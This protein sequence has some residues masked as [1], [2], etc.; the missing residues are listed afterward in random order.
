VRRFAASRDLRF[1]TGFA[2]AWFLLKPGFCSS[3][4]SLKP[5]FAQAWFRSSLVSLKL[6]L[7]AGFFSVRIAVIASF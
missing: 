3:L 2:Q 4:V 6:C 7:A 5:G 1:K